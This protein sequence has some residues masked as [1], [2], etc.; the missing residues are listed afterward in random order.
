M[1]ITYI[2]FA[3]IICYIPQGHSVSFGRTCAFQI[4]KFKNIISIVL[5]VTLSAEEL[6]EH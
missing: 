4:I 3:T 5:I 1:N 2:L 6:P